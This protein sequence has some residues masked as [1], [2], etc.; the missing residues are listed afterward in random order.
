MHPPKHVVVHDPPSSRAA[1]IRTHVCGTCTIVVVEGELDGVDADALG[2][3]AH[4]AIERATE[5]VVLDLTE[6]GLIGSAALHALIAASA[7]AT[8]RD[9]VLQ[10]VPARDEVHQAV[11]AAGVES[12]L[13]FVGLPRRHGWSGD[14]PLPA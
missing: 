8:A 5:M 2:R 1:A 9:V 11:V 13:P 3:A 4:A 10:I 14:R 12:D 6:V 7:H